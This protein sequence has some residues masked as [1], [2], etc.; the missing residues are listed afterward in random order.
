[1]SA[2]I[3]NQPQPGLVTPRFAGIATFFRLPYWPL[4]E[5]TNLDIGIVGIPW[6]G[7]T[8]NRPGPRHAPRQMRDQSSLV[9]RMHQTFQFSPYNLA[10]VAD[11]GDCPVN[12]A[13]VEDALTRIET[14]FQELVDKGIRPL[15][16]GGD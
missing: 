11:I 2:E 3:Y 5:A 1:M 8:T 12:P 16:A 14:Y 7:G 13:N 6:D 4:D 15:V 9:R 10:N